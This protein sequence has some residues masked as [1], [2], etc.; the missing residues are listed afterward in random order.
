MDEQKRRVSLTGPVILI[1]LGIIL[2]LNN[3]GV[4]KW[5]V[6]EVILRLWPVLLIAW[7]LEILIG[8]RSVWS[9]L[10]ALVLIVVVLAGTLWLFGA[11]IGIGQASAAEEVRQALDGATLLGAEV[12]IA[13][14]VG[15]L[16]IEALP[17]S[18]NLVEG[19]IR[20]GS[21]ERATPE[22]AVE[23]ETATFTLRSEGAF[24]PFVGGWGDERGWDLGLNP[25][26][27]L[28]LEVSLG[29]GQSD[30]D[31]TGLTVSDLEVSMGVGQITVILP[32]EGHFQAEIDGAIGQTIVVIPAGLAARIRVD[33][34]LASSQLP[35]EYQRRD[36]VYTLPG[37]N[38]ADNRVDL[39]VSQAIG[40][41]TIRHAGTK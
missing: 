33:T 19:V 31:L 24:I 11:G 30:V 12:V 27:P 18:A 8:R 13:P 17:E 2:L 37:Y 32:S 7:G 1:G 14:A 29:V 35:D 3:L 5:S 41:I 26:V 38:S 6:W 25:D 39:E 16:H 20:L 40:N 10:L 21:G 34:G 23:G 15:T 4:L 9:S 28:Q 36:D 22:F